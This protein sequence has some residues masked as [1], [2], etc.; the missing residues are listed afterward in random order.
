MKKFIFIIISSLLLIG[1]CSEDDRNKEKYDSS[2]NQVVIL[3]NKR[4]QKE[5]NLSEEE[6]LKR[7]E[8]GIIVYDS[9]KY[10]RLLYKF[11]S[12]DIIYEFDQ[13]KENYKPFHG[14]LSN[15]DDVFDEADYVENVGLK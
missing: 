12:G 2:I 1:G 4:L 7:E 5:N 14:D 8:I 6:I 11:N 13:E 10:I 9:G 15:L 3:E